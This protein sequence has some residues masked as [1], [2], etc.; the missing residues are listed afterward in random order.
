MAQSLT[1]AARTWIGVDQGTTNTRVWLVGGGE[2]RAI[3]RVP[4]GVRQ[5]AQEGSTVALRTALREAIDEVQAAGVEQGWS[6]PPVAVLAAGM[7]TS[8]LGLGEVPHQPAPAG[9]RDLAAGAV[10]RVFPEITPLPFLMVPG[11]R[12]GPLDCSREEIGTTDVM[13][14]EETLCLGLRAL[15]RRQPGGT[16]LN[17]GSHWKVIRIDS[18]GQIAGSHT[19]L[20]GELIHV[21]QTQTIL[22]GSVPATRPAQ[23]DPAWLAAGMR[24][25]SRTGLPRALFCVRLLEQRLPES[26]PEERLAFLIGTVLGA[27]VEALGRQGHLSSGQPVLLAGGGVLAAAWCEVLVQRGIPA[28]LLSERE[29]EEALRAGLQAILALREDWPSPVGLMTRDG[30]AH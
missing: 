29:G 18:Q 10:W 11:V 5:T 4:V 1:A 24:E 21:V 14:G 12:S 23:L 30:G 25:E 22:A 27:E 7:I 16:L 17:L 13:R 20:A 2:V 9:L 19:S 8:P 3:R 6:E 15:G 28:A 26:T